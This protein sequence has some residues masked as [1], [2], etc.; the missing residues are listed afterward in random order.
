M[1]EERGDLRLSFICSVWRSPYSVSH[2]S[3]P[4]CGQTENGV[5]LDPDLCA[6]SATYIATKALLEEAPANG[7]TSLLKDVV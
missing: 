1:G 2:V 4:N 7:A 3:C 5:D 6:E